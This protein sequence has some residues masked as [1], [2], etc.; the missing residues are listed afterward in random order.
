MKG[1]REQVSMVSVQW[2]SQDIA[3][4][5]AQLR[6]TTFVRNPARSAE[7]FRGVLGMLSQKILGILQPPRSVLRPYRSAAYVTRV[8]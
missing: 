5:R 1:E 3:V 7:A 6:H 2:R 4:A 8:Q